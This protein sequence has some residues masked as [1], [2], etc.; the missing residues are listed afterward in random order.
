MTL[1]FDKDSLQSKLSPFFKAYDL[2]ATMDILS[3]EV[4]FWFGKGFMEKIAKEEDLEKTVVIAR[5]GR[6][7]GDKFYNYLAAGIRTGGG[8]VISLGQATTDTMYM[9]AILKDCPG[10][11]ITAS[12][13]PREY[14]GCKVVKKIPQMMGLESGLATVRDYIFEHLDEKI[15]VEIKEV[16]ESTEFKAEVLEALHKKIEEI[17]KLSEVKNK[18]VV[19]DAANGVGGL[20]MKKMQDWYPNIEFIPLFWEVDGTFPNHPSDPMPEE[21]R[22]DLKEKVFETGADCGLFL[23]GDA[24]R[25]VIIDENGNLLNGDFIVSLFAKYFL[26]PEN[27]EG[28]GFTNNIVYLEPNSR[29]ISRTIKENGGKAVISKQGHTFVKANMKETNA[30]YG[31]ENSAHHYFG[32]FNYMDSGIIT[33]ALFLSVLDKSGVK[34]S[35]IL[36]DIRAGYWLSGEQNFKVPEGMTV[37]KIKQNLKEFYEDGKFCELDGL[38]IAYEDW[39]VNM[40]SSNTEPLIRFNLES[41]REDMKPMEKLEEVLKAGRVK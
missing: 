13:N 33:L 22:K 10:M 24:D 4:Y 18:K 9:A 38:T 12:H 28:S 21:N 2:R 37:D 39:R 16:N 35:E 36:N 19:V 6:E 29:V 23:D 40:R 31:G 34:A 27:L 8:N 25:C 14:N 41:N 3:P 1:I 26:K 30:I 15:D 17:S 5:D 7:N 20:L 11:M 32:A